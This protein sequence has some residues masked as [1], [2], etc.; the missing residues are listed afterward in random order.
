M[1]SIKRRISAHPDVDIGKDEAGIAAEIARW[2]AFVLNAIPDCLELP[3][4]ISPVA[5]GKAKEWDSRPINNVQVGGGCSLVSE[6]G[7][8]SSSV[9]KDTGALRSIA[10]FDF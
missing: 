9:A 8:N 4:V 1:H 7:K 6:L 3:V 5:L 10:G 2:I